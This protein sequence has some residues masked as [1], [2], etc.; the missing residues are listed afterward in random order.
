MSL[1]QVR[2]VVYAGLSFVERVKVI[3]VID[4]STSGCV[5][6]KMLD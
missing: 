1:T 5:S 3:N 6:S 2:V 4:T